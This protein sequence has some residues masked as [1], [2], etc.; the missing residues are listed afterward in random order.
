MYNT[1][2]LRFEAH[3]EPAGTRRV[4]GVR[5]HHDLSDG[6][7]S[8]S[9]PSPR[10]LA[11]KA[12]KRDARHT[13]YR[14]RQRPR[15]DT[16]TG[17]PS[18]LPENHSGAPASRCTRARLVV[19]TPSA[20]PS[21]R[22]RSSRHFSRRAVRQISAPRPRSASRAR[23]SGLTPR[24]WARR[25]G[26]AAGSPRRL[27]GNRDD[28]VAA[29]WHRVDGAAAAWFH[30]DAI[31]ATALESDAGAAQSSLNAGTRKPRVLPLPVFATPITSL[32]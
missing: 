19:M 15:S 16:R 1:S 31:A 27:R 29:A 22:P 2:Y 13:S 3:V 32:P 8:P 7:A 6:V 26:T 30:E 23:A 5:W 20:G 28:G 21:A 25:P 24:P 12:T 10:R 9:T 18:R 17:R 11:P 4:D 14:P